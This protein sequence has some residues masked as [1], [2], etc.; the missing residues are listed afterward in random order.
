VETVRQAAI[1]EFIK[2]DE[3]TRFNATKQDLK[4]LQQYKAEITAKTESGNF[5][6][7]PEMDLGERNAAVSRIMSKEEML[8]NQEEARN[9]ERKA[10]RSQEATNLMMEY[11][12]RVKTGWIPVTSADFKYQAAVRSAAATSP[13]LARQYEESTS[14]TTDFSKRLEMK[15]ADPLGVAAAERG[16]Q[17][18]PLNLLDVGNLP[19]QITQRLTA[20]RQLGVQAVFKGD[21]IK[22]LSEYLQTLPPREQVKLLTL[23]SKPLGPAIAAATFNSAAEQVKVA[24]P[25]QAIMFKL[26]GSGKPAEAQ[27]YAEGRAYLTGEKKDLLKDKFTAVQQQAG[28]R[29]DKQL[30]SAL[31]SLPGT[32]NTIK[33]AIVTTYLGEAHRKNIPLDSLDKDLLADV[34]RRIAGDTVR[35]GGRY[36][37][38]GKT[39]IIPDGMTPDQFSNSIKAVTPADIRKRGGIDGMSDDEAAKLI[40]GNAWHESDGGYTFVKDGKPLYG[41]NGKPFIFRLDDG[42][43]AR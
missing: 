42:V 39:T 12:D 15:K 28:D 36:T 26:Y 38:S 37:G 34:T 18:Q 27:L 43:G 29:I 17:L 5:K 3:A 20:A 32:R 21:E 41:K 22:A 8:K 2:D 30:G 10:A 35:T 23:V 13:S 25:D 16:I 24:R 1:Q 19:Q 6:Y 40:K 31:A 7:M 4:S 33:E 9:R 14:F 11:K